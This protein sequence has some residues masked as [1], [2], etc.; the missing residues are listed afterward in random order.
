MFLYSKVL[1]KPHNFTALP[2]LKDAFALP[3]KHIHICTTV[4]TNGY[5]EDDSMTPNAVHV[6]N[7]KQFLPPNVVLI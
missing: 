6:H 1:L 3:F 4:V 2:A 7:K 5:T